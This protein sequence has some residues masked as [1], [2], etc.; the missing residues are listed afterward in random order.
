MPNRFDMPT[1]GDY[2]QQ[3]EEFRIR[4]QKARQDAQTGG[5][6]IPAPLQLAN[7]YQRR[8]RSGDVEGANL[9]MQFAKTID[10]GVGVSPEGGYTALPG[11]GTAVG[12]IAGQKKGMETQAQKDVE[13]VMNPIIAGGEAG[14]RQAQELQYAQP[15]AEAKK[16]GE[17]AATQVA[18]LLKKADVARTSSGLTQQARKILSTGAPTGSYLGAGRDVG[19]RLVG[20]SDTGTQANA[21]LNVIA[22]NL[23]AAVPRMEGPQSDADRMYYQEQAGKVGNTTIPINDRLAALNEI[24]KINQKYAHLNTPQRGVMESIPTGSPVVTKKVSPSNIP[25]DAA[26]QLK[27]NPATA[28]QFDEI[29]GEGASALVLGR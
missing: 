27:A 11:Y 20:I 7:E 12:A 26:R 25:M 14:A 16:T 17:A 8:V 9:L 6:S 18:D 29:F 23:T 22:G 4:K 24:D 13:S 10:R 5:G 19:K 28:A 15:I 2:M 3:E 1:L 21:A